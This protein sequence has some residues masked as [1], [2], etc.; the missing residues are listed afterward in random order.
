MSEERH[1]PDT[2][3][4]TESKA[5]LTVGDGPHRT[6]AHAVKG[7]DDAFERI[8]ADAIITAIAEKSR[9]D[10]VNA[11]ILRTGE[12][13]GALTNVLATTLALTPAMSVPS[14]LRKMTEDI[15]KRIR[16]DAAEARARGVGDILGASQFTGSA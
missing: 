4:S 14:N 11:I 16:K 9:V 8:L 6:Y 2:R 15:A 3:S 13:I 7:Y 10:D 12:M 5:P 1:G